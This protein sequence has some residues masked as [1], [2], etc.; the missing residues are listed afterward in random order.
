MITEAKRAELDAVAAVRAI[1]AAPPQKPVTLQSLDE[2]VTALEQ[3]LGR[4][5]GPAFIPAHPVQG[6]ISSTEENHG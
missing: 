4:G 3:S 2:R 6:F 1:P 5:A